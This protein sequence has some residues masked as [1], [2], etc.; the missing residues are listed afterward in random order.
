[1]SKLLNKVFFEQQCLFLRVSIRYP[2]EPK[3]TNIGYDRLIANKLSTFS[4]V[5]YC[6]PSFIGSTNLVSRYP[7]MEFVLTSNEINKLS[8]VMTSLVGLDVEK[9]TTDVPI[10]DTLKQSKK[11]NDIFSSLQEE[12]GNVDNFNNGTLNSAK[13]DHLTYTDDLFL[14]KSKMNSI[15]TVMFDTIENIPRNFK[16]STVT[17]PIIKGDD[18]FKYK[19]NSYLSRFDSNL[20][21][22]PFLGLNICY[23]VDHNTLPLHLKEWVSNIEY[24]GNFQKLTDTSSIKD[25]NA[26]NLLFHGFKGLKKT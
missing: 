8:K 2:L 18:T 15:D 25:S 23:F 16:L 3:L 26:L 4:D 11:L 13:A 9:C 6:R 19:K 1:M 21:D 5:L 7:V 20:A 24:T 14:D 22:S 10:C 17:K 12:N